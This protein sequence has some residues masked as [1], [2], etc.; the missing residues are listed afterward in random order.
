M[1]QGYF[2]LSASYFGED[3]QRIVGGGT[4]EEWKKEYGER[5]ANE[6]CA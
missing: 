5:L 3:P 1:D 6:V 4:V 2:S